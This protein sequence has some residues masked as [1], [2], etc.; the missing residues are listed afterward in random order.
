MRFILFIVSLFLTMIMFTIFASTF[1]L[2]EEPDAFGKSY[3]IIFSVG[4]LGS[5]FCYFSSSMYLK[6]SLGLIQLDVMNDDKLD[7]INYH[8]KRLALSANIR[9]PELYTFE[10]NNPNVL[11]IGT[12]KNKSILAFSTGMLEKFTVTEIAGSIAPLIIGSTNNAFKTRI[13]LLSLMNSFGLGF[14]QWIHDKL[15]KKNMNMIGE[16][17]YQIIFAITLVMFN[18]PTYIIFRLCA[19]KSTLKNDLM[20]TE[21][22]STQE[23]ISGLSRIGTKDCDIGL[24]GKYLSFV[25]C[26]KDKDNFFNPFSTIPERIELLMK[27]N[28]KKVIAK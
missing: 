16:I 4:I 8:V 25:G 15:K 13:M 1:G 12:N 17:I 20:A 2:L 3:M 19:R 26:Q 28:N 11:M 22:T 18:L 14:A 10:N 21:I 24:S 5:I 7:E 27:E 9:P 23:I 6:W